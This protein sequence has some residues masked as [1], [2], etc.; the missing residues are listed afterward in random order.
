MFLNSGNMDLNRMKKE[1]IPIGLGS[2]IGAGSTLSPFNSMKMMI[3]SHREINLRPEAALYLA[4]LGGARIIGFEELTGNFNI[5]KDADFIVIR[6]PKEVPGL[7][8]EN[9]KQV[10]SHLIFCNGENHIQA[11]YLKGEKVA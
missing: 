5:G 10:L 7:K 2:D 6:K 8:K 4:T 1:N 3:Y 9:T 11:V